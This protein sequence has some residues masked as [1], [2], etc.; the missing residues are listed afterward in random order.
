ML[1]F[2]S[3]LLKACDIAIRCVFPKRC[4]VCD[5]I[6]P[7]N[8][9]YCFCSRKE[10]RKI[11]DNICLHCGCEE[12]YCV[13]SAENSVYLPEFAAAYVYDG[14]IRADILNFKFNNEKHLSKK[15]ATAMAERCA[16][17]FCNTDFDIVTFVPMNE[18]S[19]KI[20]D[21]N[22]SQLLAQE[23]GKMLFVPTEDLFTKIRQTEAQH[24]LGGSERLKN[25][26]DSIALIKCKDISGKNILVCD[27]VKTT[28]ATLSQCVNVLKK[29][30]ANKVCCICVAISDFT[31]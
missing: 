16:N 28:G 9:E 15:L 6:I 29:A 22:Q 23:V 10:S 18:S 1:N 30:N 11:G 8:E 3:I 24:N 31:I 14:K 12:D 4:P 2:K 5:K 7:I 21:Y 26:K 13:C 17:V 20:R 19:R 25:V 27:D